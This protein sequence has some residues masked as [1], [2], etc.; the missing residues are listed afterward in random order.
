MTDV[1]DSQRTSTCD[2]DNGLV[3]CDRQTDRQTPI[4]RIRGYFITICAI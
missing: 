2:K 4:K 3:S 1:N